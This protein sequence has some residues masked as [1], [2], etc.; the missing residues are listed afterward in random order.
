MLFSFRTPEHVKLGELSIFEKIIF[1][2]KGFMNRIR[3]P[4]LTPVLAVIILLL[5]VSSSDSF[6][7][8]DWLSFNGIDKIVHVLMYFALTFLFSAEA[9]YRK[10]TRHLSLPVIM[11]LS[12]FYGALLEVIQLLFTT[13]RHGDWLDLLA[14]AGG[15][16]LAGV[17]SSVLHRL[18]FGPFLGF[19]GIHRPDR[20]SSEL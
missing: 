14:N 19:R 15:V 11:L 18:R 2:M 4:I 16:L 7:Q 12:L 6:P 20:Q 8:S 3:I 17:L 5:S 9:G 1:G 10:L 13:T